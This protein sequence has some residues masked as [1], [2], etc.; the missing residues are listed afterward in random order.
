VAAATGELGLMDIRRDFALYLRELGE[1]ATGRTVA[2]NG[3]LLP[4]V[5]VA[6]QADYDRLAPR[7]RRAVADWFARGSLRL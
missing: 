5:S 1:A 2:G 7:N 3:R 4:A 6:E